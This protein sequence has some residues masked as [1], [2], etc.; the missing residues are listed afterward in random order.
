M[1]IHR[2]KWKLT[3][4]QSTDEVNSTDVNLA[5]NCVTPIK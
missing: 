2:P 1:E 5:A 3:I 4:D